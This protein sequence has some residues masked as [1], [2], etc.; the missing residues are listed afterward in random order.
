MTDCLYGVLFRRYR[1]LK[2]PL[3]CEVVQ[4]M[5]FLGHRFVGEGIPDFGHAF[6]NYTYFQPCGR[7]SLSSVQLHRRLGGEKRRK[8]EERS[9]T[10]KI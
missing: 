6:S 7:F 2:L 9:N 4:K 1:P 8:Q 10:G 5:W 3:S